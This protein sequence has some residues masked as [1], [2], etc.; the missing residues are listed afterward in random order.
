MSYGVPW[1]PTGATQSRLG[2]ARGRTDIVDDGAGVK[3]VIDT[4]FTSPLASLKEWH[5][6][7]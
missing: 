7:L 2:K 6:K 1:S 4:K 5:E 3:I